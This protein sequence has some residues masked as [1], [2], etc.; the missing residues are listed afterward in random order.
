VT[1]HL[2]RLAAAIE[3][4]DD[5]TRQTLPEVETDAEAL[6]EAASAWM[7]EQAAANGVNDDTW[8][9]Y[10]LANPSWMAAL[11]LRRYWK[12]HLKEA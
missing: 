9:L 7:H 1:S 3:A 10:E 8:E 12:K 11:G 2:D 5:W 4:A 6:Q